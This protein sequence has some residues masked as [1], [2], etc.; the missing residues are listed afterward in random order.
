MRGI[1]LM[2]P[3]RRYRIFECRSAVSVRGR[4]NRGITHGSKI[5]REQALL[6]KLQ[7]VERRHLHYEIMRMLAVGNGNAESSLAFL[8]KQRITFGR[9][10]GRLQA[11]HDPAG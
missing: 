1:L 5:E 2:V 11:Q 9:D 8:E 10:C 4:A 6:S 7:I 3:E